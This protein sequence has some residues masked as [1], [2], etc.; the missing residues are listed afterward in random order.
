M[1][2]FDFGDFVLNFDDEKREA[3]ADTRVQPGWGDL[4]DPDFDTEQI[5]D[6]V[7]EE[8]DHLDWDEDD[9]CL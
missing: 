2:S 3:F 1:S 6:H 7:G 5:H 9:E 8:D 4:F